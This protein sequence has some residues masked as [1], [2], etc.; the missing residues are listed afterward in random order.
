MVVDQVDARIGVLVGK[1]YKPN[2][3]GQ[4]LFSTEFRPGAT[5]GPAIEWHEQLIKQTEIKRKFWMTCAADE[6]TLNPADR[7]GFRNRKSVVEYAVDMLKYSD[8]YSEKLKIN[9]D[10]T[11]N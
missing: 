2:P 8:T 11:L 4:P 6:T 9:P 7:E 3:V 5:T 10:G 1:P